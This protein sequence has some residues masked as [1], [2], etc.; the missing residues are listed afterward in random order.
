M[1]TLEE[2]NVNLRRRRR[3]SPRY[4]SKLK[5][6]ASGEESGMALDAP[7]PRS[8]ASNFGPNSIAE[9]NP[10]TRK[11]SGGHRSAHPHEIPPEWV[12]GEMAEDYEMKGEV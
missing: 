7:A 11:G 6:P 12:R 5:A 8:S 9:R 2:A 10:L 1:S 4:R 3:M